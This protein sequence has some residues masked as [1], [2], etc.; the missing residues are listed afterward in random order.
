[1]AGV[2]N[3]CHEKTVH[4]VFNANEVSS[5]LLFHAISHNTRMRL[6]THT[7]NRTIHIVFSFK[8]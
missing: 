7:D 3:K 4:A 2:T 1:M 5:D 8:A 6:I